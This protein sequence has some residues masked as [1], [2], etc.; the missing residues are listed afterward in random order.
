MART[1]RLFRIGPLTRRA[2]ARIYRISCA[3]F[4]LC[5]RP[6]GLL[7]Q[8]QDLLVKLLIEI[9]V[10]FQMVSFLSGNRAVN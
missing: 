3:R 8:R 1:K 5:Y 10:I 6:I 7:F 4:I 2:L 9:L